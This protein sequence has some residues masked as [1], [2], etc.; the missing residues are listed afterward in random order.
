MKKLIAA[1]CILFFVRLAMPIDPDAI[2][3]YVLVKANGAWEPSDPMTFG[4]GYPVQA[5]DTPQLHGKQVPPNWVQFTILDATVAEAQ[6]YCEGW[7][8]YIDWET[9]PLDPDTDYYSIRVFVRPELVSASGL[10]AL[11]QEQVENYLD[12]W[13]GTFQSASRNEVIFNIYVLDAITSIGFWDYD[14]D[15]LRFSEQSYNIDTGLYTVEFN[16]KNIAITEERLA[17]II[18]SNGCGV[19]QS[20]PNKITYSC[21]RLNAF[22]QFKRDVKSKVD[23]IYSHKKFYFTEVAVNA[24]LANG[25]N[26]DLTRQEALPYIHNRLLD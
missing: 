12:Q 22:A 7:Y 4:A 21:S 17:G 3:A 11:T 16:Y 2:P 14:I 5:F 20:I 1:L 15:P 26:L 18:V 25:G 24:A 9:T 13:N 19:V 6:A 23:S 8:R 10:N